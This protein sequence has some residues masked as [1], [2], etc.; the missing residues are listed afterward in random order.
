MELNPIIP[1][2]VPSTQTTTSYYTD[3]QT[4]QLWVAHGGVYSG[5]YRPARDVLFCRVYRQGASVTGTTNGAYGFDTVDRDNYNMTVVNNFTITVPVSGVWS[6]NSQTCF[7]ASAANQWTQQY[8]ETGSGTTYNPIAGNN[9][10]SSYASGQN[11]CQCHTVRYLTGGTNIQLWHQESVGG[12]N[13]LVGS[14][15]AFLEAAYLGTG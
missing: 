10:T 14:A 7:T 3:P 1:T 2:P 15:Q 12:L 13:M 8:L 11:Y 5:T 6:I 9:A 4:G